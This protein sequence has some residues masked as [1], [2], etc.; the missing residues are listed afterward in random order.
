MGWEFEAGLGKRGPRL[1]DI[2]FKGERIAY[3]LS[4]QEAMAGE[5]H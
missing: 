3:E 1:F 5:S 4:V 2:R